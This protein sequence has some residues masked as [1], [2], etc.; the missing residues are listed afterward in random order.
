MKFI[1]KRGRRKLNML[2]SDSMTSQ[3]FAVKIKDIIIKMP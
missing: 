3:I 1:I 2:I